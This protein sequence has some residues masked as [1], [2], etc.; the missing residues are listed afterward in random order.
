MRSVAISLGLAF[1]GCDAPPRDVSYFEAHSEEAQLVLRTCAAGERSRECETA[2]AAVGRLK[3]AARK[4][5]YRE[6]VE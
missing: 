5:R 6:G 3:A 4:E 1:S 2:R